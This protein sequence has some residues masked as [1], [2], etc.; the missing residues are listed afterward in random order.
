[1]APM[2]TGNFSGVFHTWYPFFDVKEKITEQFHDLNVSTKIPLSI[3]F[4]KKN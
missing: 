4:I 3:H 2:Y 1:M